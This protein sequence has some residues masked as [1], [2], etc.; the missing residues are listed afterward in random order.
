MLDPGK[1]TKRLENLVCYAPL[2]S[3]QLALF[4]TPIFPLSLAMGVS[5]TPH[6]LSAKTGSLYAKTGSLQ[7]MH[8]YKCI[9]DAVYVFQ[10]LLNKRR[11]SNTD[12]PG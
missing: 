7:P 9:T 1:Q 11:K 8:A 5:D 10:I 2:D 3:C 4:S 12:N 6:V